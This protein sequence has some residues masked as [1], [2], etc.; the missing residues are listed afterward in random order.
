MSYLV[1]KISRAKWQEVADDGFDN[2]FDVSLHTITSDLKSSQ[3]TLS[4]WEVETENSDS[5]RNAILAITSAGDRLDTIDIIWINKDA[6]IAKGIS[7]VYTPGDTRIES[8]V[9]T[10]IDLSGLNYYSLGLVAESIIET[11]D[12]NRIQRYRRAQ[13]KEIINNAINEGVCSRSD[14]DERIVQYL[15][16]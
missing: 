10:H 6:I 2:P 13:L 8:L 15:D 16:S 11:I 3:N 5:L 14:F 12:S 7:C 1:R 4:V 9:E